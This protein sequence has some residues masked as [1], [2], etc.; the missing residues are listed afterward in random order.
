[1][2][3]K[4]D[5][6]KSDTARRLASDDKFWMTTS[7]VSVKAERPKLLLKCFGLRFVEFISTLSVLD[8]YHCRR[9]AIPSRIQGVATTAVNFADPHESQHLL[10][11]CLLAF[12]HGAFSIVLN[13]DQS[14]FSRRVEFL[15]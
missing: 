4:L 9:C 3:H 12:P 15:C 13:A 1:M 8:L 10:T 6:D 5:T 11:D 2:L 7:P 14:A